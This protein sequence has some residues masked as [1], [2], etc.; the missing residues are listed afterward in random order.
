MNPELLEILLEYAVRAVVLVLAAYVTFL[1]K[2]Y[3][4]EKY[5]QAA[6]AAAEKI[7]NV[8]GSGK[9]KKLWVK[10]QIKKYCK[11]PWLSDAYIDLLIE[12]ACQSLETGI[13][14]SDKQLQTFA[15]ILE[16]NSKK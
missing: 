6:V 10:Q 12:A 15:S 3:D 13:T 14:L 8:P 7:F 11:I 4:L 16:Q 2:K 9:E 1:I 5:V